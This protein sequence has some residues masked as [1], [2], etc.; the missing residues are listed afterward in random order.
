MNWIES[1]STKL[2]YLPGLRNL[3]GL[4]NFL[5]PLYERVVRM[6]AGQR[7][8]VRRIN[9]MDEI[10][11]LPEHRSL[12]EVYEPE[13][14]KLLLPQIRAGD[15]IA[16][17]GAH[18]GIYAIA[19]AKRTGPQGLVLAVEADPANAGMLREH[20]RLNQVESVVEV[21][22]E[23]LSSEVGEVCWHSQNTQSVAIPV[24]ADSTG[25]TVRMSTL[26]KVVAGRQVDVMLVDIEGYEE[27]ALRGGKGLLCDIAR[28]PRLIVIEVHPYNWS[29]CGGSSASLIGFLNECGY[30]VHHL[31]GTEVTIIERYGHVVA[32]PLGSSAIF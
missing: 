2:R 19:F 23:A 25:F 8:L 12:P 30:S 6:T 18:F 28:R 24:T 15:C 10:R 4:W 11:I 1:A 20:L 29:L 22:Q 16:D 5:R 9:G 7:G 32:T 31:D 26:D 17:I 3:G 21:V 13:V 14:W 27:P